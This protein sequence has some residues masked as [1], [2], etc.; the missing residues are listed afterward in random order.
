M[1]SIDG[2]GKLGKKLIFRKRKGIKDAKKYVV[3]DNPKTEGQSKQRNYLKDAVLQWK[4]EGYSIL[5]Y[6]AWGLY[7]SLQKKNLSGY[8]MFLR[9]RIN[10]DKEGKTWNKLTN[11]NIYDVTGEGFK[12]DIDITSDLSGILYLGTSKFSMLKEFEGTFSVNKYTF[13]VTELSEQ[14]RYYFYIKNT[15]VNEEGRTGIYSQKTEVSVPIIIDI[16]SPA[17]DRGEALNSLTWIN[18]NNPANDSG[19]ITYIEIWANTELSNCK[20]ATFYIV[21]GSDFS[22]R[23]YEAIGTVISGSKQTFPV[24][25]TVEAGDYIGIYFSAGKLDAEYSGGLGIKYQSG[26]NIPCTKIHFGIWTGTGLIS[27]YGTGIR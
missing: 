2:T 14:K 13:T 12:V 17:I 6:S 3:P 1:F 18:F 21:N 7:A 10:A 15:S 25:I 26:D 9:E 22:T 5:D 4:T 16:G 11:C 27:L 19:R 23:D 8:N 24:D 20:V